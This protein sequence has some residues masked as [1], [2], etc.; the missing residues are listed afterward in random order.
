V[1]SQGEVPDC[2]RG[3]ADA[4]LSPAF[5]PDPAM[6]DG[7]GVIVGDD[8]QEVRNDVSEWIIGPSGRPAGFPGP[9]TEVLL[10][11]LD[12][13]AER[14]Q[15]SRSSLYREVRRGRL[16]VVK[17]GHL[18]RV[19]LEDLRAYVGRLAATARCE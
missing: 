11:T 2:R 13:A 15:V 5:R 6:G 1:V 12:Q 9:F 19:R 14:L 4:P 18:S 10:L 7:G 3:L 17:L 16:R 8:R